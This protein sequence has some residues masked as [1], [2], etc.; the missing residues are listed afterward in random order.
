MWRYV[1]PGRRRLGALL[2]LL[3]VAL[4]GWYTY[5][6]SDH[7]IRRKCRRALRN[8]TGCIV[9][10][11]S[12]EFSFF[13]GI[14][15]YGVRIFVPKDMS[16]DPVFRA[17]EVMLRHRPWGVLATGTPDIEE[18]SCPEAA[19]TI[20]HDIST[21][22]YSP[23]VIAERMG[24][25]KD[26]G[27]A[28]EPA[29]KLPRLR[30]D[31][32]TVVL[33]EYRDGYLFRETPKP[34]GLGMVGRHR[35]TALYE[36]IF[37]KK[38]STAE[39]LK[40]NI[41]GN[42]TVD[43]RTGK[44]VENN[45]RFD[46]PHGL[47]HEYQQVLD[48]Y[49]VKGG[50]HLRIRADR[51]D[52]LELTDVAL[53]LPVE[54]GN[55][56]IDC[57]TG[58]LA[59]VRIAPPDD[60]PYDQVELRGISGRLPRNGNAK[61]TMSGTIRVASRAI[62]AT[63]Q[64]SKDDRVET[65][66]EIRLTITDLPPPT[67]H[68]EGSPLRMLTKIMRETYSPT[69]GKLDLDLTVERSPGGPLTYAGTATLKGMSL[70]YK[71]FPYPVDGVN[72][73][74]HFTQ[75]K[76]KLDRLVGRNGRATAI[77][78]GLVSNIQGRE[79]YEVT[80]TASDVPLDQT[81]W[82][83]MPKHLQGVATRLRPRGVGSAVVSVRR[84][85]ND[86][87]DDV[88]LDISL[89]G[90][91]GL[92][93]E[94]FPY[95]ADGLKGTIH[96]HNDQVEISRAD[97]V[98]GR[99]GRMQFTLHG[100][101]SHL[102]SETPEVDVTVD[103][104]DLPLDEVLLAALS[105]RAKR[106]FLALNPTG[107]ASSV[108]ARLRQLPGRDLDFT[109]EADLAQAGYTYEKFPYAVSGASG[110]LT[111]L[112]DKAK[113]TGVSGRHGQAAVITNGRVT[114][115]K[116]DFGV[117]L[118]VQARDMPLDDD[119]Y[120]AL[121][122]KVQAVWRDLSPTGQ[123]DTSVAVRYNIPEKPGKFDYLVD[124]HATGKAGFTYE[125][126]AYPFRGVSGHIIVTPDRARLKNITAVDGKMR[127]SVEGVIELR[128]RATEATLGPLIAT[129]MPIDKKL[130]AALPKELAGLAKRVRPGGSAGMDLKKLHFLRR[131]DKSNK[132][133]PLVWDVD[134]TLRLDGCDLDLGLGN[135]KLCGAISGKI[136]RTAA[137]LG[138][139]AGVQLD[140]IHV[141]KRKITKI[142]GR[143][144]KDP[145]GA[146]VT[147]RNFAGRT[148][149]GVVAGSIEIRLADPPVYGVRLDVSRVRLE[150]LF[151]GGPAGPS[152]PKITGR[153]DGQLRL[154]A[155]AGKPESRKAFGKIWITKAK[156]FKLPVMLDLL[157]VIWLTVPEDAAFTEGKLAYELKGNK[158][159]FTEISLQGSALSVVGSG[160]LNLKT[161]RLNLGFLMGPP[162]GLLNLAEAGP[163]FKRFLRELAE[164]QVTGTL[165]RPQTRTVP[166]R[167]LDGTIRKLMN[168]GR[169]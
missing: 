164:Y 111:I 58:T 35:G 159:V 112:P 128:D 92:T 103:V 94:R 123:A 91:A 16:A 75:E 32:G 124:V 125:G 82:K 7:R 138:L 61:F 49:H 76:V 22:W 56:R 59:I 33:R 131:K 84:G 86:K 31:K 167:S 88:E 8:I 17:K 119:L 27:R 158:L 39:E 52:E 105:E 146:S 65:P 41:L 45:I 67:V 14:R 165:S 90:R 136:R 43:V 139:D 79:N 116:D 6:T 44:I 117:E 97:P 153:L 21:G 36:V 118:L 71:Y 127:A 70:A 89:D 157:H 51:P 4:A 129:G 169:W 141:G 47:P 107:R 113:I 130:L 121:P 3:V 162:R 160:T 11:D 78:T 38:T 110:K 48:R 135:K 50:L 154:I 163:L 34:F 66:F 30:V 68:P 9:S 37:G 93:Y 115:D 148:H 81:L 64:A 15:L 1:S 95:P 145:G 96:V 85:P 55:L 99:R 60:E 152:R 83:A 57:V 87:H 122:P 10:I 13:G 5:L 74:I 101:I 29:P 106:A 80:I 166:L 144:L 40:G 19:L 151:P 104:T 20:S 46:D 23:M 98:H 149:G 18:I 69:K 147:I 100:R 26:A 155:E 137:G 134:G 62:R 126:F 143:L 73:A 77:L 108:K 25:V 161:E 132:P 150:Q 53:R 28:G 42:C 114:W 54:E 109:I 72:G 120:K 168:P 2:L 133:A 140:S 102:A 63:S 156:M 142:E 24:R 12:A